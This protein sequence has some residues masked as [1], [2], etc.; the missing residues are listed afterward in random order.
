MTHKRVIF[1]HIK[2]SAGTSFNSALSFQY[3]GRKSHWI[4]PKNSAKVFLQLSQKD[5][6]QCR[7]IRGHINFGCH[8]WFSDESIYITMLRNPHKRVFS[9][10]NYWKQ[11]AEAHVDNSG[12]WFQL[13]RDYSAE[14]LLSK[15][16]LPE[17][18][19]GMV[20]QLSGVGRLPDQCSESDLELAMYNL[21]KGCMA[22][23]LTERFD[24]SLALFAAV[25]GW[26]LPIVH[27]SSAKARSQD[28]IS[29]N[30]TLSDLIVQSNLLDQRLYQF[31]Q[32]IF[33]ERCQ[34]LNL[35]RS[36]KQIQQTKQFLTPLIKLATGVKRELDVRR[37]K[38]AV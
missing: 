13:I 27:T 25:L 11:E 2:K 4:T 15:R 9:Y 37:Q 36:V 18:E 28:L 33:E 5:R 26:R 32:K 16:M 7:L 10:L 3:W 12:R 24:Q 6:D 38:R 19:N 34:R 23:G 21:E 14:E 20:R 8:D 30:D 35:S 1:L 17:L 29:M 31:A 22:F